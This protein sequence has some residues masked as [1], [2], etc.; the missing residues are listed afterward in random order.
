MIGV[1][2]DGQTIA[3]GSEV[4]DALAAELEAIVADAPLAPPEQPPAS[5]ARC[6]A[7]LIDAVGPVN[8][9]AGLGYWIPPG[10]AFA[11]D[12]TMHTSGSTDIQALRRCTVDR[13]NWSVDEWNKLLDG[14]F[15]PWAIATAGEHAVS[16]CHSAR[17]TE[18]AAEAGVWTDPEHRGRGHAAAVTAAWASVPALA[19]RHLFYSTNDD[20][21]SSQRVAAR[22][23]LR[24]IGWLWRLQGEQ[25]TGG[26]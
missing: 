19:G 8:R 25:A 21:R 17:L 24:P 2:S 22:L 9:R 6:E 18:H 5:L 7:L 10:T 12:A 4:S 14:A 20:N 26:A 3:I 1:A 16:V 23:G 11:S 13:R 15:G